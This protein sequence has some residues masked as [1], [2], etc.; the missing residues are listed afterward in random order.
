MQLLRL[1]EPTWFSEGETLP[2]GPRWYFRGQGNSSWPLLPSRHRSSSQ[3]D[4]ASGLAMPWSNLV[5]EINEVLSFLELVDEF[6]LAAQDF[7]IMHNP[8][9][10]K[11]QRAARREFATG[12]LAD[13]GRLL[14]SPGVTAALSFAQH[15]GVRT[16]LLDWTSHPLAALFFAA[17]SADPQAEFFAVWAISAGAFLRAGADLRLVRPSRFG[18]AF[19]RNQ[20]GVFTLDVL[21]DALFEPNSG[22]RSHSEAIPSTDTEIESGEV[23]TLRRILVPTTQAAQVRVLLR[24]EGVT[25]LSLMPTLQNA[26]QD[27]LELRLDRERQLT[28]LLHPSEHRPAGSGGQ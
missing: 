2:I 6:G 14:A 22:W 12:E 26:A 23:R 5:A 18:N 27:L 10:T 13:L 25:R 19:L 11:L 7:R 21:A 16:R 9:L 1:S 28:M 8:M 20:H 24:A 3:I 17:D 15:H 4:E